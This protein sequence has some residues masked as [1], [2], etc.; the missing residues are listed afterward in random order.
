MF[1]TKYFI[2][3]R[4]YKKGTYHG[5]ISSPAFKI[6]VSSIAIGVVVMVIAICTGIGLQRKIQENIALFGGHI[7]ITPQVS[8]LSAVQSMAGKQDFIPV[9]ASNEKVKSIYPY[10]ICVSVIKE[11]DE[12]ESV[13]IKGVGENFPR[14]TFENF[15][16]E[17]RMPAYENGQDNDSI[18]VSATTVAR[19]G[20][21]VGDRI[22]AYF[23]RDGRQSPI[24]RYFTIAAIYKTDI[25]AIDE[26]YAI[27]SQQMVG[28]INGWNEDQ[29]SGY[30]IVLDDMN[31]I[32][33]VAA[34][35]YMETSW[36]Y[37]VTTMKD[38]HAALLDWVK[39]F[40]V[41]IWVIIAIMTIVCAV[42]MIT[43]MLILILEKTSLIGIL[44]TL[45]A[46]SR[47]VGG[48]FLWNAFYIIVRAL[49]IGNVV[50]LL[51]LWIQHHWGLIRLDA[52]VYS[53]E[54]VPVCFEWGAILALNVGVI[55]V[56]MLMLLLPA[57][58]ISRINPAHTVRYE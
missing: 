2:S 18:V 47:Y 49:I 16:V 32:P 25:A 23:M 13:I 3:R 36:K 43:I 27:S 56:N 34:Q 31:S 54:V 44:R 11:A 20:L 40:D 38:S 7:Q 30:E 51:L 10:S 45:G 53:V 6:A 14:Q 4:I 21:K 1:S 15:I 57:M 55:L 58:F 50:A 52:S 33:D 9:I 24:M 19:L 28:G 29:V 46:S 48:I 8:S 41:N 42:N 37:S 35:V 22:K 39:M 26:V 17:G 5:N 12:F